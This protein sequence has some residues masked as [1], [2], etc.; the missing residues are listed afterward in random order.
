[1][2]VGTTFKDVIGKDGL[3]YYMVRPVKLQSTPS[4]TYYNLGLGV[5]D[6]ATISFP[7]PVSIAAAAKDAVTMICFPNPATEIVNVYGN[8]N[9]A[10]TT[11]T[12]SILDISGKVIA[13]NEHKIQQN[14][15]T[16]SEN[17]STFAAG[18]YFVQLKMDNKIMATQKIIKK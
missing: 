12:I 2:I 13:E 17:L 6:S 1:M 3:Y 10:G 8:F 4:G 9:T 11:A 5:A 7:F 16:I 18:T 15:F 14:E